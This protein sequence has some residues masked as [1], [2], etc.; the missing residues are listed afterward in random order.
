[1]YKSVYIQDVLYPTGVPTL[2]FLE[3]HNSPDI[4]V[5]LQTLSGARRRQCGNGQEKGQKR[6]D[7]TL[8]DT[9]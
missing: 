4:G 2:S 9:S 5:I 8:I 6:S 1:M 7:V 3:S